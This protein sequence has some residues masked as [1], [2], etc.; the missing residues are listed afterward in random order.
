MIGLGPDARRESG[1]EPMNTNEPAN[2][3]ENRPIPMLWN[4]GDNQ[5]YDQD[6][7]GVV[8]DDGNLDW[9]DVLPNR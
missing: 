6:G 8:E 7:S 1:V 2:A 4:D 3:D 5:D 9:E